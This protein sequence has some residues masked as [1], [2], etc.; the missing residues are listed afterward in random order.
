MYRTEDVLF[1]VFCWLTEHDG[2]R[3]NSQV[4]VGAFQKLSGVYLSPGLDIIMR[5]FVWRVHYI[6]Y[7]RAGEVIHAL[8]S[9][10]GEH[11]CIFGSFGLLADSFCVSFFL[12]ILSWWLVQ[13]SAYMVNLGILWYVYN[14]E[15]YSS[16][17]C[18]PILGW[19]RDLLYAQCKS[20]L[21]LIK[22]DL[23]IKA[24]WLTYTTI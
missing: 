23:Y 21:T 9:Q 3:K 10:Q 17:Y 2:N 15:T 5:C 22:L 19:Q 14:A 7:S 11:T 24:S 1:I 16:I 8:I 20:N 13:K 12:F 18:S 6:C 4:C